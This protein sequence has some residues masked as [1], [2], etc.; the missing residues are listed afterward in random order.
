MWNLLFGTGLVLSVPREL[1]TLTNFS[2]FSVL[3]MFLY[4]FF[5]EKFWL[6]IQIPSQGLSSL[7]FLTLFSPKIVEPTRFRFLKFLHMPLRHFIKCFHFI[8]N[9]PQISAGR[10]AAFLKVGFHII[11]T[12]QFSCFSPE[13]PYKKFAVVLSSWPDLF[14]NCSSV[15]YQRE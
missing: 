5:M 10:D 9:C 13:F 1:K 15:N 4:R 7:G 6:R 12:V 2:R 14:D 3:L 8:R 11:Q